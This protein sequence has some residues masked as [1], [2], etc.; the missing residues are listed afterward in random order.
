MTQT[1]AQHEKQVKKNK[2]LGTDSTTNHE[3]DVELKFEQESR[4]VEPFLSVQLIFSTFYRD[5]K[6]REV[7]GF[8]EK[9]SIYT[10]VYI[11]KA[12]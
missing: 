10:L 12:L 8:Y 6:R 1:T 4:N 5:L 9:K 2:Q 7:S 3:H 11:Y